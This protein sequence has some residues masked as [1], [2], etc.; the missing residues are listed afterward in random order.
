[1][2]SDH[3]LQGWISLQILHSFAQTLLLQGLWKQKNYLMEGV[4]SLATIPLHLACHEH[5]ASFPGHLPLRSL[6]RIRDLLTARRSGRWFKGHVCSQENG[7][8]DSLGMRLMNVHTEAVCSRQSLPVH[9][10][11]SH[12]RLQQVR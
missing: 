11:F 5:V 6:D 8:G 1:M 4:L 7:V 10:H 9:T 3:R 2:F 12:V